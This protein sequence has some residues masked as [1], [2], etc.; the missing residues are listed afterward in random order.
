MNG[1]L[2][3]ERLLRFNPV[4]DSVNLQSCSALFITAQNEELMKN[5]EHSQ[6]AFENATGNKKFIEIPNYINYKHIIYQD[7]NPLSSLA[8][9]KNDILNIYRFSIDSLEINKQRK[10]ND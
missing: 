10:D 1:A 6:V 3:N 7:S 8:N 5:S 2:L 9:S 4:D